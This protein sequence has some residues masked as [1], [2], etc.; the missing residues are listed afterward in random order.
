MLVDWILKLVG[1]LELGRGVLSRGINEARVL[2]RV[3]GT[4]VFK[5]QFR[6]NLRADC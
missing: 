2:T 4:S 5:D 6:I 3:H 1:T